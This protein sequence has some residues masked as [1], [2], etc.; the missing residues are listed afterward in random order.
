MLATSSARFRRS[1]LRKAPPIAGLRPVAA[2]SVRVQLLQYAEL[3]LAYGGL[4]IRYHTPVG[5]VSIDLAYQ[6]N[7]AQFLVPTNASAP[8]GLTMLSRLPAFQFFVN[9]G[10]TF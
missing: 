1:R 6:L 7:P 4:R 8:N 9:L 10:S 3:F 5:P 2:K